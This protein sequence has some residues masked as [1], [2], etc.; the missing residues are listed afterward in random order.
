M[1]TFVIEMKEMDISLYISRLLF[2]YDCVIVPEF[3][4]FI[5]NYNPAKYR[6]DS[7]IF[8]PPSKEI[9]FNSNLTVNDGL[10]TNYI[11]NY[12][13]CSFSD[14]RIEIANFV[15]FVNSCLDKGTPFVFEGIGTFT[16]QSDTLIF[17]PDN[18]INRLIEAFG[19]PVLQ[20]PLSE[21]EMAAAIY[22]SNVNVKNN[23]VKNAL[24]MLPMALILAL[25]PMKTSKIPTSILTSTSNFLNLSNASDQKK[26]LLN[27]PRSL[28]EVIDKLSEAEY[29]LYYSNEV[30]LNSSAN[31]D[32]IKNIS[33]NNDSI[34]KETVKQTVVNNIETN[35]TKYSESSNKNKYFIIAG[36]FVEMSR[37][38]VFCEEL[39]G[40]KFTPE[41][42]D[43]DHKLRIS[44]GSFKTSDEANIALSKFRQEHPEY[45]VWL[46]KI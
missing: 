15:Q 42:L 27:N 32:T 2:R 31:I 5:A 40:K 9:A 4:G 11:A 26:H 19:L 16:K 12:K 10:L 8:A 45:P 38:N 6:S 46:L 25:L 18:T 44:V 28:S 21:K 3:G 29:A 1:S 33:V 17:S 14:A 39:I 34:I 24:V 13:N 36:S 37:V 30:N 7:H 20:M 43:R 35:P 22:V 23:F 41:I